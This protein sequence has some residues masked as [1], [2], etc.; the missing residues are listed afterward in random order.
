MKIFFAK[1]EPEQSDDSFKIIIKELKNLGYD[2]ADITTTEL[3]SVM[4]LSETT[5][6]V[7]DQLVKSFN[8]VIEAIRKCDMCIFEASIPGTLTGLLLQISL[9]N[10]KPTI[11]LY[12]KD[13]AP[14]F[15]Y[16]LDDQKLILQS[17]TEKTLKKVLRDT[18]TIAR[19]KRDKRFNFFISPKLL[20]FLDVA[21][22]QEGVTKSKYIRNLIVEH[23][24]DNQA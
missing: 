15:L 6:K 19:E 22:T 18:V 2:V 7:K 13:T 10:Q 9:E 24:R 5:S 12:A 1:I 21:S 3:S 14:S 16:A 8:Q 11:V 4:K 23:M 17:Y 20:E